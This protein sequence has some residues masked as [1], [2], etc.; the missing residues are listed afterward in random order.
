MYWEGVLADPP[1][2]KTSM[3]DVKVICLL[4]TCYPQH[5]PLGFAMDFILYFGK[6]I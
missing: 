5:M 2:Q 1:T 3:V 4:R 6:F